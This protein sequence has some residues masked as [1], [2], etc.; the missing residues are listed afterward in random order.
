MNVM[1]IAVTQRTTEIGLL[2]ALG[3]SPGQIRLLF[4]AEAAVLSVLGALLGSMVGQLGSLVIR[5]LYP[6][7]PAFPPGWAIAAALATALITGIL[8]SLLP[9]RRAARLEPALALARR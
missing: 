4:F 5:R 1:L 2:K 9:A 3:A 8:F 7:L 6:Q